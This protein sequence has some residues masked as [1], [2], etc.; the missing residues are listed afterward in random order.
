MLP[1]V[2]RDEEGN[3]EASPESVEVEESEDEE[4]EGDEEGSWQ[5]LFPQFSLPAFR[6][7]V[8][9]CVRWN[10]VLNLVLIIFCLCDIFCLHPHGCVAVRIGISGSEQIG[11]LM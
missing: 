6:V 5:S 1:S 10:K 11:K 4:C 7:C 8:C 2:V 3:R 9:V